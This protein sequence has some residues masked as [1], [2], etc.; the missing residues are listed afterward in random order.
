MAMRR[1]FLRLEEEAIGGE[2]GEDDDLSIVSGRKEA[3]MSQSQQHLSD[4]RW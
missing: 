3:V 2:N 1:W 4:G